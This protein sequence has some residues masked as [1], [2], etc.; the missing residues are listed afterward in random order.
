MLTG[1]HAHTHAHMCTHVL[2][3]MHTHTHKC[4]HAY[5]HAHTYTLRMLVS[6]YTEETE[7]RNKKGLGRALG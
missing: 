7:G 6:A 4:T 3:H 2:T 1:T 5:T